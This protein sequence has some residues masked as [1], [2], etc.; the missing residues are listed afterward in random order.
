MVV[1]ASPHVATFLACE[2][3]A[4]RLVVMW[5]AKWSN[6]KSGNPTLLDPVRRT[7]RNSGVIAGVKTLVLVTPRT[8]TKLGCRRKLRRKH[9]S[10]SQGRARETIPRAHAR[11]RAVLFLHGH[12]YGPKCFWLNHSTARAKKARKS[13]SD[14]S[15]SLR[16]RCTSADVGEFQ[17]T[18]KEL[19]KFSVTK[20][21]G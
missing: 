3:E 7:G 10:N 13:N 15:A 4:A 18:A 1:H 6:Q 12:C 19:A 20:P 8:S 2:I 21:K 16:P 9:S 11:A 17:V 5:H 14:R